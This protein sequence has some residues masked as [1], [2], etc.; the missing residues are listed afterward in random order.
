MNECR[1]GED[2]S[3]TLGRT[4][5]LLQLL[6]R[7]IPRPEEYAELLLHTMENRISGCCTPD[8]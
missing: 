4:Y 5:R 3:A 6:Q 7:N 8:N 2:P 1:K